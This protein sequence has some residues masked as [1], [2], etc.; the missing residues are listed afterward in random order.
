MPLLA[1]TSDVAVTGEYRLTLD[2]FA[3]GEGTDYEIVK[4]SG[5]EDVPGVRTFDVDLPQQD[6]QASGADLMGPRTVTV[7]VEMV[8][9][10]AALSTMVSALRDATVPQVL[11]T[12]TIER[13]SE[14]VKQTVGKVRRRDIPVDV[15][16]S[17][18]YATAALAFYAPDPRLYAAAETVLTTGPGTSSSGGVAPPVTPPVTPSGSGAGGQLTVTNAGNT[19]TWPV[20]TVRGPLPGFD[21]LQLTTGRTWRYRQA[22]S[23]TDFVTVDMKNRTVLLN[24]LASRRSAASGAWWDLPPGSNDIRFVPTGAADGSSAELRMRSAWL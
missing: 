9:T 21:L 5:M 6:G 22:L 4:I 14:P 16:F 3:F 8:G 15:P 17:R 20:L 12:L 23:A 18:G 13:P 7:E 10:P 1:T 11:R 2:G 24:A 19:R